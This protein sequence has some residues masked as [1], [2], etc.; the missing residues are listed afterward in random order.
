MD[1]AY[2]PESAPE[3]VYTEDRYL[4]QRSYGGVLGNNEVWNMTGVFREVET[5]GAG[6]LLSENGELSVH[7]QSR[8]TFSEVEGVPW[9]AKAAPSL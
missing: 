7:L 3:Y 4:L 9:I 8:G 2:T 1:A 5:G 6:F